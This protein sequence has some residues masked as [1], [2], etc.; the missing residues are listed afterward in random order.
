LLHELTRDAGLELISE[1]VWCL[2]LL[3]SF[4]SR[5]ARGAR[6]LCAQQMAA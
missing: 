4:Q 2:A 6:I 1:R 3:R 5:A